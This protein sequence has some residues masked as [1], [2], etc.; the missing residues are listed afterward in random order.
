MENSLQ[1]EIMDKMQVLEASSFKPRMTADQMVSA[2]SKLESEFGVDLK[3]LVEGPDLK[4]IAY[5]KMS[6]AMY[7]FKEKV[8]DNT[9]I[10]QGKLYIIGQGDD[11]QVKVLPKYNQKVEMTQFMGH[12]FTPAERDNLYI[13][14]QAGAVI[15]LD[16]N[17]GREGG[18]KM[19]RC[20]VSFD[21]DLNRFRAVAVDKVSDKVFSHFFGKPLDQE[22]SAILKEGKPL[23]MTTEGVDGKAR[24]IVIQFDAYEFG[25]RQTPALFF[26]PRKFLGVELSQEQR[27][28][29]SSG[30][31]VH[32]AGM[33]KKDG[34][35]FN[36]DVHMN[37]QAKI[38]FSIKKKQAETVK[39]EQE[40]P[41]KEQPKKRKAAKLKM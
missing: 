32:I 5:G 36:A 8:E 26:A 41:K 19:E 22:Q 15:E 16:R 21:K 38:E 18:P 39:S 40:Q 24:N 30:Q 23:M 7:D 20:F 4:R 37:R 1:K 11:L 2:L 6:D 29:L 25:L 35:T 9:Y 17:F 28:A 3:P 14:G 10:H 34:S 13:N 12:E 33:K 31:D 27:Q